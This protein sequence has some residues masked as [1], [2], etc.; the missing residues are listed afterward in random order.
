MA[1][2]IS[3]V[4]CIAFCVVAVLDISSSFSQR[5]NAYKS[6]QRSVNE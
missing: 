4:L 5:I 3:A 6:N 2:F 1:H